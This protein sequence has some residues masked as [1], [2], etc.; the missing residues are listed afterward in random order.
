MPSVHVDA[1]VRLKEDVPIHGLCCGDKGVVVSA[2]LSSGFLCE[3]EF[4]KSA[5]SPAV[6]ALLHAEQLDIVDSH[7]PKQA[8]S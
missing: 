4:R 6:R 8:T 1:V 5:R 3:V 7:P 2:W